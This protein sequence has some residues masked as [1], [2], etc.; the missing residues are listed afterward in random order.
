MFIYTSNSL[1]ELSNVELLSCD[2]NC[3]SSFSG[4]YNV[5]LPTHNYRDGKTH[6][7][8]RQFVF[9]TDIWI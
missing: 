5:L 7:R 6:T 3:S 8:T 1:K 4:D 9:S 2:S